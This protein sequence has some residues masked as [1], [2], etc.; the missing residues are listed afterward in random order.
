MLMRLEAPE[1]PELPLLL[2]DVHVPSGCDTFTELGHSAGQTTKSMLSKFVISD[3]THDA[4]QTF[5]A[6]V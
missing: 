3:T 1:L 5:K 6:T 2:L 4:L